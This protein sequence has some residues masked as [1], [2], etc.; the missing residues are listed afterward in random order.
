MEINPINKVQNSQ[1]QSFTTKI[2]SVL[3]GIFL[4]SILFALLLKSLEKAGL[5]LGL[6]ISIG[7][8][9][10][11]FYYIKKGTIVR[12]ITWGFAAAITAG[13]IIYISALITLANLPETI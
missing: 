4:A 3:F 11:G 1:F 5:I 7:A 9:F 8:V 13:I 2:I 10:C 12:M 6:L